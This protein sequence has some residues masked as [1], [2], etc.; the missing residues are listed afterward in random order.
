FREQ[1]EAGGLFGRRL[2]LIA[3][4]DGYEPNRT[5]QN[6]LELLD[7]RQV[8]AF[9]GNVGT[10]TTKIALPLALQKKTIFFGAFTGA[11][12]LRKNPPDRYV[13]NFRPSY[14][15]ETAAI[16]SYFTRRRAIE[17]SR[18]AVFAQD[19][20]FGDA[21][22]QGV[23]EELARR[24]YKTPPL[25]VGYRRNSNDVSAAVHKLLERKS[26]I[27]AVVLVATYRP[28]A[29]LIRGLVDAGFRPIF[30]TVSFVGSR[31]LADEL[32]ELG[33]TYCDG[34]I[35]TQV[36]PHY[37]A[38]LP[39]VKRYRR[40]LQRFAPSEQPSFVSLEGYLVGRL[41]CEGV[42]RAGRDVTTSK[43][44]AALETMNAFDLGLDHTL[45]FGHV[46]HQAS[47]RVY[48]TILDARGVYRPLS[49]SK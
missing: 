27:R 11:D 37:D 41:L 32:R 10:P 28:A 23:V 7:K 35:V 17:P 30:A 16:V 12:L 33:S 42:R 29:R 48:A 22:Y 6:M 43:L 14:R 40:A 19:D 9:V 26:T 36:V 2:E 13:F 38:D 49:L 8:F 15:Q 44:I 21:G 46:R 3:L 45:H 25:R 1:N 34:V 20:G 24:G 5:L 39:A 4:D 18:I 31:A 47:A